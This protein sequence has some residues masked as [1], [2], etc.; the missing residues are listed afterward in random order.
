MT[1]DQQLYRVMINVLWA[2]P[3]MF[4]NFIP[5]LGGMHL[6]MSFVGS[7]GT[8]MVGSGLE[9]VLV[10][11]WRSITYANGKNIPSEYQSS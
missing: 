11:F 8:L 2:Y 4:A 7:V 6:L 1:A 5:R 9:E 3:E 10:C